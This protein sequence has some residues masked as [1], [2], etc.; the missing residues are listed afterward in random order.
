[1]LCCPMTTKI[2]GYPFEVTTEVEGTPSV[3]I[4]DQVKSLDWKALDAKKKEEVPPEVL[5][6]VRGRMLS[7]ISGK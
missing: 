6:Q 2:K 7:L 3:I 5:R 4:G 1:M